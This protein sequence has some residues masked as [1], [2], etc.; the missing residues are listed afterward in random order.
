[1]Y[2]RLTCVSARTVLLAL[3]LLPPLL[4]AQ[5]QQAQLTGNITDSSGALVPGVQVTVT[6]IATADIR[7]TTSDEAGLYTVP[8]LDP[9]KYE[10]KIRKDGF[11]SVTRS[12]V[13]LHVNQTARVDIA[14]EV[15]AVAESVQVTGAV[16]ALQTETSDLGQV[17]ENRQVLEL[18]LNGRNTIALASLAAGVRPQGTF[19]NNSAT[20]NY[21]GWGNFSANGG[22][23]NANEVLVDGL[24]VTTS[25][26]GGVAMMPAVDATEEFKVQTN[27]F[28]AEFDRTA[29]GI[30][31]LSL[32]SGTNALHGSVYEFLRNDKFDSADFFTNRAGRSK[33]ALRYNQFGASAGGA[34]KR[35]K[36]F[37]F[38]LYEGFRQ[39][40]GRVYTTT[41][42]TALEDN[43][44]FS[45]TRAASGDLRTI[46]D[47]LSTRRVG[48]SYIRSPFA[49]NRIPISQIDPVA[50]KLAN[51]LWPAANTKG[52]AFTN[53]NN[54]GTSSTQ[55][56]N[57]DTFTGKIDHLF[58]ANHRLSGSY[59][60]I[61]PN[62]S[63][64]DPFGNKTTEA[65]DGAEGAERSQSVNL[66]DSWVI[67]PTTILDLRAGF[68]RFRDERVPA[69]LGIDLTQFGFPE[70]YNE[71]VQWQA[72]PN[73]HVA[74]ISDINASTGSTIFGV[75]N[76]YSFAGSL[77]VVR[78]SHN[79]KI[80]AIYRVLQLNR[81]QSNSPS[82]DFTFN[83]GFTQADPL[84]S[85]LT[86]GVP[87]ASFLLGYVAS[88]S[89]SIVARLAL[90]SKYAGWYFQDDWRVSR[91]LTLNLGIRYNLETF[92]T[93]R[94]NDLARFDT[95][96]VPT[97]AAQFSGLNLHGGM[98]FMTPGD[99]SPADAYKKAFAPRFG[100]AYA[101]NSNTVIRGGY[102]I[103]WLP[104]N[105]SVTN[106]NGNNPAY[107]VSTPFN[108]SPDGGITPADRLSNPYPNGLLPIP[109]NAAG[110]DTLIGQGL[111]MYAQGVQPGYMQQWNFDIQRDFGNG[112]ALDIAYAGSKGTKLPVSLAINR[113][114]DSIWLTQKVALTNTVPNP[115]YGFVTTGPLSGPTTTLQ[116]TLL[117]FPQFQGV[118][119]AQWPIGNS[120]YHSMQLKVLKRFNSAGSM[121]AA[122][123][124]S[125]TLTD[126][127]SIT[128]WLEVGGSNGG[129]YD[130]YNRRL[131]KALANFDS[132][133]RLVVSYNYELPF[134]K[135]KALFGDAHGVAGKVVSGWQ[136]NGL[137]TLQSGY[138][139]V[140]GRAMEVGDPNASTGVADPLSRWFNTAAFTPV[141]AYTWGT[142]PRTLPSTRSDEEVNFD[143]S[144]LKNTSITD[145]VNLQFRSEFFNILNHPWFARPDSGFGNPSYGTVNAVMNNPRQIQFGLKLLF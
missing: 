36:T 45:Q 134:G 69:S 145:R 38:A 140:P 10:I 137:T 63:F 88:G 33:A 116:Q 129:F 107:S 25:A 78:G 42:P 128:S 7:T 117:P 114:S 135:G 58:S 139:V 27:N 73:I 115:F 49:N 92:F 90:Q 82:G 18:P 56:T 59:T 43:G 83:P 57:Q 20:G 94:Y 74:G 112:L 136:I 60:F 109:G 86:S 26:I 103:F 23:A 51:Y 35:D 71:A 93:D 48:N 105:L 84:T 102:G 2:Q 21:T 96:V 24:P 104:N 17:V 70:S 47:P 30:I 122:Y 9:G 99:R 67:N 44:D 8:L 80:G 89:T 76:N 119:L 32:K 101:L 72:V 62:L 124:L 106:G 95:N 85:S 37:F 39:H 125:K 111:G 98:V 13:E 64:W 1:V 65:D 79:M 29:G 50:A 77:N 131:D 12:G 31:N 138:P 113:I 19:G 81:T 22:L 141:P 5:S 68:L 100:L 127:E 87:L 61:Q 41:V 28:S 143:F 75:Q 16:A 142:A 11:R 118:T 54:F 53:V 144:I 14:L 66:D 126:T 40:L 34:I 132:T 52:S 55:S 4:T 110:A 130:P 133:H 108:S 123:T 121:T 3:L 91:K 97:Q 120:T 6:N 46:S 15:G